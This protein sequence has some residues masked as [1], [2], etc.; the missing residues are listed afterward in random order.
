ME[1]KFLKRCVSVLLTVLMVCSVAV[2]NV[3]AEETN[4]DGKLKI[5]VVNFD[6]KWGDV[7][8]NVAKMVDY[9]EKA[10]EDNVEFLVFP[11]MCV[12][13]YCYSYDL[14]DAQSK[15]AVKTAETVDGPTATKI[16][17]LADEYDMWIAYGETEVVPND[18]KHAYNSVFA[19]SP[20]GTVTTYQKM[21]PVEGIWCKAGSTPT[22]LNTAEGK[23]G[24]SICYDTYAVPELERYYDAQGCRV[25]LNPTATSRGSYD[26]KDGSLNT[27]NWQW[28]YENRLESIVDRDGMYI[29]SADLAGKEYD[30]NGELLYNFPGG[31]VVIGPGGTSDSGK[32]SK[33]YAG[34]ASVQEPGMYTGEI[35]L[36][37]A[38]GGDVNSSI[39]QPNLYTEW[40]KDLA[41][42]TKEDKVSSGTVSDPTIATVNFQAV[43]G[44]LDK[45]LEQMENYIVTASKS[46]ADIIVFPEM[47]LQGYCSAYDPESATYRL[48]VD[49]AITK[50]GY[51]AKTLSEYAKKYDMY[52]IFGASEKIPASENPDELDQAYNSA[53]CCSP[54]GT[55]TT[56]KKIQPVEGA[57][58]KSGTNPVI[59]ETPYGGIG[60]SICKDTYSYP[61][62]E[63]YYGAKGCKFIVNPTA[64]SRGGASR[65]SWYYS[66][67]L[68]SIVDRD[69]LV[70]VSADLCGTQYDNDG[71]A[72]STF[73]GGSCVIAPLRS[74][75]NSSYV[76]Y[77][78][79]S[80]KYD[81][82]NVGMS[83]GRINTASKK[84]S[85]GF[86]IAGFN[87]SIYSTMYGVLAGTK[88]VSE[89]TATDSAIVSVSTEIVDASTLKKSGYSLES[90]VYNV[91]TGLTTPSYGDSIYKKLSN[92]TASV[93]GDS[94]S[95]VYSVVD[96]KL[97]K[98]DTTYSDGKLSFTT[99]G[100]TY[101]V[102]SYKELPTTVTVNKTAKV[103][104]KGTYQ[105]K[106]NVTN[107]KGATT[108]KSSDSKV[109]K[110]SST[111]K[112]TALKKGT[113][114][115]TVTN[116]GVSSTVKF[117]VRKPTLNKNIVRLKA[118]K[119][120]ALKITGKIGVAKFKSSNTKI[121][122]VRANGK[123]IA[124]KKGISFI[125]VNTNGIVLKCKVVVK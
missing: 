52:V 3:S 26:E 57:W 71:N 29:A 115:V 112:V 108:Y 61:E 19:C 80:S 32:Y 111:G 79:G 76:D 95:E 68:E 94:T 59:I 60:L 89:I 23:V 48:A 93:V 8:A 44:D 33:D 4:G 110:V 114:T 117:T 31:S 84:Y 56:Y 99:S 121:A 53:F 30:E 123:V 116:N 58:C 38:R 90:K 35:T 27:T 45:N 39:F 66:R 113:A 36:S 69:K 87:P 37:T 22:I 41:D 13:C 24:V 17:K 54:D 18:S 42:D 62:L 103:Y 119:S 21:H 10:K 125:T 97:T 72:H 102:V 75:K 20:D 40:Y 109:V 81:P 106:A 50:K 73:P 118:K 107:G 120:F 64:T 86:S 9:I 14:D 16:A 28:Y 91:E 67:R 63:R 88:D 15:M 92:V 7:D 47:A 104:V 83:I 6:S 1:S 77:V 78:A 105:I 124:K 49:K 85:I 65:W 82:E 43:W 70:V 34:G 101:C 100:G 51:Y 46:D 122:T 96:G 55:V 2:I 98:V 12:S 74:A 25:L 5:S 11:E